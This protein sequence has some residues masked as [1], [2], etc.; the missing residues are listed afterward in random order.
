[1]QRD[2]KFWNFDS[3]RVLVTWWKCACYT[4]RYW[5][6]SFTFLVHFSLPHRHCRHP[7]AAAAV[8]H[9]V[10]MVSSTDHAWLLVQIH[11]SH[12]SIQK[13]RCLWDTS[14]VLHLSPPPSRVVLICL[15]K[16]SSGL[17]T[18][19][20]GRRSTK[21]EDGEKNA[22]RIWYRLTPN[23]CADERNAATHL[24]IGWSSDRLH[25]VC[26]FSF[27]ERLQKICWIFIRRRKRNNFINLQTGQQK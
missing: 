6:Q 24:R 7:A 15:I 14:L 17:A 19:V 26:W 18:G 25:T 22:W 3:S 20:P 13:W 9:R 21:V 5:H 4:L 1:M 2:L 27:L 10:S 12:W 23:T 11:R 16:A 8:H